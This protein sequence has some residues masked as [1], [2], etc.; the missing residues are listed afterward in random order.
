[1]KYEVS[2]HWYKLTSKWNLKVNKTNYP[3]FSINVFP[4]KFNQPNNHI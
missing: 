2:H 3:D 4:P 1:M